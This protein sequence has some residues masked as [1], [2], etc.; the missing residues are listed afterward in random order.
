MKNRVICHQS[1]LENLSLNLK[2]GFF[3]HLSLKIVILSSKRG[4]KHMHMVI[5]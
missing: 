1:V 2:K 5:M 4:K 3:I